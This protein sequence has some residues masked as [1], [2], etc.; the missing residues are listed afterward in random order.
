MGDAPHV[1]VQPGHRFLTQGDEDVVA[2][3]EVRIQRGRTE[4]GALSDST[5][6]QVLEPDLLQQL[7]RRVQY[8]LTRVAV[9][10]V[11]ARESAP[12]ATDPVPGS[13]GVRHGR[14]ILNTHRDPKR[15]S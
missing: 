4:V 7:P 14:R 11:A 6:R 12:L 8:L 5:Q 1:L 9:A 13:G 15:Q 3:G 10:T 2:A